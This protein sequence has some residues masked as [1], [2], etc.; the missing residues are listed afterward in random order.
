MLDFEDVYPIDMITV[1][2]A[3]YIK[4]PD[5]KR[6]KGVRELTDKSTYAIY[7]TGTPLENKVVEMTEIIRPLESSIAKE[8]QKPRMTVS[9]NDYRKKVAPVYLRRTK[10]DVSLELPPLIQIEEWEEFGDEE[11]KEYRDAV[12]NGKFMRMRR[13]AWTGGTKEKSPKLQRLLELT[14]EAYEN[15]SKVIVFTFFRDV[16][17]TVVE[18]LG[19]RVVEPIH[20][21]VPINQRQEIIDE[22]RDSKTKNVLVAQINTAAH[23]L[24]IQFANT[25]IFCEPQI[26]PSLESQAVARAYR[27][28]QVD[29]V[30]VYRLLT[31]NSIDELMMD[32]LGNKQALF[33][34]F[35]DRSHLQDELIGLEEKEDKDS[36]NIQTKIIDLEAERLN[37][38]RVSKEIETV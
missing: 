18:A 27:M 28:G 21:G 2:E 1:D 6:T 30:F 16:I 29:N 26:K 35:A 37:I 12:A 32:M 20:G 5:A 17:T 22:F 31:V 33:D 3:H 15:D 9:A 24:N 36:K 13:A 25:I 10:K 23:G 7:L 8:V 19:D 4:N 34:Q 14:N 38:E 11:F